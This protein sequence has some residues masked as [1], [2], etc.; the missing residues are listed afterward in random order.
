MQNLK[1]SITSSRRPGGIF[2]GLF[3]K[4]LGSVT[5][6]LHSAASVH[7]ISP[8]SRAKISWYSTRR[9]RAFSLFSS[10]QE[11][12]PENSSFSSKSFLWSLTESDM[13]LLGPLTS[14]KGS[15]CSLCHYHLRDFI[16][17]HHSCHSGTLF[18]Y[19][20]VIFSIVQLNVSLL[21]TTIIDT[22][23]GSHMQPSRQSC[24]ILL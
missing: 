8:S 5:S 2:C 21:L 17:S 15:H 22:V 4:G 19:Y 3:L 10:I 12:N 18:Q 24:I 6:I 1:S 23:T 20:G 14:S 13:T 9:F 7:S 11:S 16:S